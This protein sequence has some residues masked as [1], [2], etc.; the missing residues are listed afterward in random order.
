[1]KRHPASPERRELYGF[2]ARLWVKELDGEVAARL[3]GD[4]GRQLLPAF[5]GSGE[6][7]RVADAAERQSTFDADYAQL[8]MVRLSPYESFFRREDA[9][10]EAGAANP[11]STFLKR[12]GLE[13]DLAAARALS[14]DHLGIELEAMAEL[15]RQEVAAARAGNH[16][17]AGTVRQVERALL[18][19]HLLT[20]APTYLLAARRAA[21]TELYRELADATLHFLLADHESLCEAAG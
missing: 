19:E 14:P 2:L 18:E 16:P 20:W 17:S 11:L 10:I 7:Q 15:C 4:L 8:T 12:Y 13:A 5:A 3:E 1:M 6:P 21:K 9:Q